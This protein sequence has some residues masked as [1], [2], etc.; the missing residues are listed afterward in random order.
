MKKKMRMILITILILCM[1]M[2]ATCTTAMAATKVSFGNSQVTVDTFNGVPAFYKTGAHNS[3]T[4]YSCAAYVKR[5]YSWIYGVNVA[6][7]LTGRTPSASPSQYSFKSVSPDQALPGDIGYQLNSSGS[8]HWFIIKEVNGNNLTVIEQNWKSGSKATSTVINR[9]VTNGSTSGLK[10]FT[11]YKNDSRV[12]NGSRNNNIKPG[13]KDYSGTWAI[14]ANGMYCW[15]VQYACTASDSAKMVIDGYNGEANEIFIL[16]RYG[17][18]YRIS[19]KHAPNLAVNAR[20]GKDAKAGQQVTLHTWVDNDAASLWS[21]EEVS[22]GIR[23]RNKAN[24]NLVIDVNQ[25]WKS[26]VGNR[27]NLWT[28]NNTDAQVFTLKKVGTVPAPQMRD[29]SG[30]WAIMANAV[31]CLNVQFACRI[32]DNAKM[33][34]DGYNGEANEIFIFTKYGSYYR[35]SPAHAP[36]LAVNAQYGKDAKAGQQVSLHTWVDNDAASLWSIEEVSG[37]IRFRN[38]ANPNLVIDVNQN[39]KSKVG[40]RINLWTQNNTDAQVFTLKRA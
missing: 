34:I 14:M 12:N 9:V 23:F 25:N 4:T 15:N 33:V 17:N 24:P 1:V 13:D 6:N 26:K 19:P 35:I 11:L 39:W 18:Y 37:G 38:K 10:V 3:D 16:T 28:Q 7:L 36:N 8:G 31:Y 27:I 20:Y 32:S 29:Y 30:R 5:Y 22:G 2:G 40:N 21:I